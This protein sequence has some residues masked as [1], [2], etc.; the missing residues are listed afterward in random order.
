MLSTHIAGLSSSP[1]EADLQHFALTPWPFL[2][3]H[4]SS[5]LLGLAGVDLPAPKMEDD[6]NMA[7]NNIIAA[8]K[9][10]GFAPPG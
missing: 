6:P 7:C 5:W 1:I 9:K 10:L 3:P 4:Q 8:T 2:S